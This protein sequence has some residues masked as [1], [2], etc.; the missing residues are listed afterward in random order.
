MRLIGM[1][2]RAFDLMC[3][4]ASSRTSFGRPLSERDTVHEWIADARIR[5]DAPGC[6]C[7]GRRG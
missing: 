1:A 6:S 4:R 2:E 5:I 7:C 3:E